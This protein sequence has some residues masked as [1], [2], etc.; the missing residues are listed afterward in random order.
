MYLF[1]FSSSTKTLNVRRSEQRTFA[2][3]KYTFNLKETIIVI[4]IITH[5]SSPTACVIYAVNG[6]TGNV[7]LY[8]GISTILYIKI[9]WMIVYPRG[10]CLEHETIGC[11]VCF[12]RGRNY[13][14]NVDVKKSRNMYIDIISRYL[15]K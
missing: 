11:P 9:I 8:A 4:I 2:W 3:R 1:F 6:R 5:Y 12:Q 14:W 15:W 10:C 7:Y 13:Y